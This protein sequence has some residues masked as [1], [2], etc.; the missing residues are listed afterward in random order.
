MVQ[1]ITIDG[2]TANFSN[3][4]FALKFSLIN[5]PLGLREFQSDLTFPPRNGMSWNLSIRT[6]DIVLV[7]FAILFLTFA[8]DRC[9]FKS[10]Y[11]VHIGGA[12]REKDRPAIHDEKAYIH[13]KEA[14]DIESGQKGSGDGDNDL[15]PKPEDQH[16]SPVS[17]ASSGRLN[18]AIR[19]LLFLFLVAISDC[20]KEKGKTHKEPSEA[21]SEKADAEG[22]VDQ[23]HKTKWWEKI[24]LPPRL[25]GLFW[26]AVLPLITL[27]MVG[28]VVFQLLFWP[29]LLTLFILLQCGLY[30]EV[31]PAVAVPWEI[32]AFKST[33]HV[34]LWTVIGVGL[35]LKPNRMQGTLWKC[36]KWA[37]AVSW[38]LFWV[39]LE[40]YSCGTPVARWF[41]IHYSQNTTKVVY[42]VLRPAVVAYLYSGVVRDALTA[43]RL[44]RYFWNNGVEKL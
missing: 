42:F 29:L 8:I 5:G 36:M 22:E 20:K 16:N 13:E 32:I 33:L 12:T 6:S 23:P 19:V 34:T 38:W 31:N 43:V 7:I 30:E 21:S 2:T 1:L 44:C 17:T 9:L 24:V 39:L 4:T 37:H 10:R 3:N 11:L 14:L 40:T 15:E 18:G 28:V 25:Q 27:V 35:L 41:G 26:S